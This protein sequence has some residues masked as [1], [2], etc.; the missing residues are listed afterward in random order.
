MRTSVEFYSA[1][2]SSDT[3]VYR[4]IHRPHVCPCEQ[5]FT[6]QHNFSRFCSKN[7]YQNNVGRLHICIA[8]AC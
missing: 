8:E 3:H 1:N 6:V 7:A 2:N 4:P 5:M